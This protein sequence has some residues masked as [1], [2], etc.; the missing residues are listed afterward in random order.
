MR[1]ITFFSIIETVLIS[2]RHTI[3]EH[4]AS[5]TKYW[6]PHGLP[7][8]LIDPLSVAGLIKNELNENETN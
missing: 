2:C 5:S 6:H 1:L 3:F 4:R 7:H 8:S